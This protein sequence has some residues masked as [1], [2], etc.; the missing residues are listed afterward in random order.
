MVTSPEKLALARTLRPDGLAAGADAQDTGVSQIDEHIADLE[1]RM[2]QLDQ[3]R[4]AKVDE[5]EGRLEA[6]RRAA[7]AWTGE[8]EAAVQR[9]FELEQRTRGEVRQ[10]ELLRLY[11]RL[12]DLRPPQVGCLRRTAA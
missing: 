2:H 12:D 1:R 9:L 11:H 4:R 6:H 5:I 8:L 3:A 7:E 10:L